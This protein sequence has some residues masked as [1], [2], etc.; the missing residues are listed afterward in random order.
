M[1]E[2]DVVIIGA[3]PGGLNCAETL[4]KSGKNVLLL[5][6][7]KIIGPKVCA[8]GLTGKDLEYFDIPET[9]LDHSFNE[10]TIHTPLQKCK[11]KLNH[12]FVWTIDRKNL[13]QWQLSKL[14][15]TKAEVRTNSKVTEIGK[16]FIVVNSEKI[17][18]NY[19]VG[20]D[21]TNSIVRKHLGLKIDEIGIAIQY[22]L[23]KQNY[24]KMEVFF[25]SKLF[26]SWYAWIFPHKNYVSIG[27]GADPKVMSINKLRENFNIWLT[28]NNIDISQGDFQSHPLNSDYKGYKFD[29]IFLIGGAAGLTSGLTGEGIYEALISGEEIAKM[30]ID[31]NHIPEKLNKV[32]KT[33]KKHSKILSILEKSGLFRSIVFELFVL[34]LKTRIFDKTF[35]KKLA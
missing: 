18:Y 32:I 7:H 1:K 34:L 19:L 2:Y 26:N 4:A 15:K 28:K 30:I 9:L 8:G 16:D 10:A 3:G 31:K 20:A 23:P 12:D 24:D 33:H 21:G 35:I 25:D 29:D 13:G 27:T 6:Q 14:K 11:V 22:I 17:K 5:E